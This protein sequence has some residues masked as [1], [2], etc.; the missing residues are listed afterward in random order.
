MP[1]VGVFKS[2]NPADVTITPFKTYKQWEVTDRTITRRHG[3]QILDGIYSRTKI[4]ISGSQTAELANSD[5]SIQKVIYYSI[6]HL[7]Y[8]RKNRPS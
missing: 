5:G 6:N 7:F 8:K 3:I 2:I 1:K 4:P